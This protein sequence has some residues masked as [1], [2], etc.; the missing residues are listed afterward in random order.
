VILGDRRS[1]ASVQ[2]R[3]RLQRC[4]HRHARSE[5]VDTDLVKRRQWWTV[6]TTAQDGDRSQLGSTTENQWPSLRFGYVD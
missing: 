5:L 1:D 6:E 4:L 2:R 3:P